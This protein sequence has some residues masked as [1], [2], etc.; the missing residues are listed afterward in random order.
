M[1]GRV[2]HFSSEEPSYCAGEEAE[3]PVFRVRDI[4]LPLGRDNQRRL[5]VRVHVVYER[6]R[7]WNPRLN[8][9]EGGA[10][11]LLGRRNFAAVPPFDYVREARDT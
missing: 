10:D 2:R 3:V 8:A 1:I 9:I 7:A 6:R 11:L 5:P 4:D